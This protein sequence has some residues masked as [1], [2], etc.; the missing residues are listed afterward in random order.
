MSTVLPYREITKIPDTEPEAV[1]SLWNSTYEEID[2]NLQRLADENNF[3]VCSTEAESSAKSVAK[4]NF[5][6]SDGVHIAVFF[7]EENS[8]DNPTLNISGTGAF[9]IVYRGS[10]VPASLLGA[11]RIYEFRFHDSKWIVCG[12][13]DPSV[14]GDISVSGTLTAGSGVFSGNVSADDPTEDE[15][16]ATKRYVDAND[17][18]GKG[19]YAAFT[20]FNDL[21]GIV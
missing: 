5:A 11:G 14:T 10:A 21:K 13:I 12:D 18:Y 6:L 17:V 20:A 4:E 16:L 15:H 9:P 19:V 2:A 3:A 1:P 8:A 7:S